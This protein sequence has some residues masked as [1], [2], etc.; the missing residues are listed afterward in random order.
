MPYC[1]ENIQSGGGAQRTEPKGGVMRA[2]VI[3]VVLAGLSIAWA[4]SDWATF[5]S[6]GDRITEYEYK[7]NSNGAKYEAAVRMFTEATLGDTFFT[8]ASFMLSNANV[9]GVHCDQWDF[10]GVQGNSLVFRT[11]DYSVYRSSSDM[12][13]KIFIDRLNKAVVGTKEWVDAVTLFCDRTKAYQNQVDTETL[14]V[15]LPSSLSGTALLT[16][17]TLWNRGVLTLSFDAASMIL[18]SSLH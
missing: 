15:P 9:T 8:Q 4:Q 11:F 10:L 18:R 7:P 16:P 3:L 1:T 13:D 12:F 6:A 2:L 17:N 5:S 14:Y